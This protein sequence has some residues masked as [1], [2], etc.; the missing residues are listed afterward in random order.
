M[1]PAAEPTWDDIVEQLRELRATRGNP[2]FATL[3]D[4]VDRLRTAR[5]DRFHRPGRS[6]VFDAFQPGR[7]RVDTDLV[8][9][10]VAALGGTPD[11]I[12][13]W[14][15]LCGRANRARAVPVLARTDLPPPVP[16]FAGRQD[17]VRSVLDEATGPARP[18]AWALTGLGGVG[19]S[20]LALA[21]AAE[22]V[23]EGHA[24][25]TA[26]VDLRGFDPT[27]GPATPAA[28]LEAL[29]PVLG[30]A[31]PRTLA[32]RREAFVEAMREHR[33]VLVVENARDLQDLALL[34][35]EDSRSTV[36]I[37]SRDRLG[38]LRTGGTVRHLE[39]RP[40]AA[41]HA[42]D[43]L[44]SL[45]GHDA[46]AVSADMAGALVEAV[47]R[48]P[49]AVSLLA[50]RMRAQ[51]DWT[52]Q[53]HLAQLVDRR[54]LLRL[55][56]PVMESVRTSY[57]GLDGAAQ[58][59]LRLL[60]TQPCSSLD[61]A[62]VAALSGTELSLTEDL[63]ESLLAHHLV[64]LAPARL[65][66]RVSL[67][68]VVRLFGVHSGHEIDRP[69]EHA[70]ARRR[71]VEHQLAVLWGSRRHLRGV[72]ASSPPPVSCPDVVLDRSSTTAWLDDNLDTVVTLAL[73]TQDDAV[74]GRVSELVHDALMTRGR[75]T[76]MLGL[77]ERE[78]AAATRQGDD[79]GVAK[80]RLRQ[81]NA[82]VWQGRPEDAASLLRAARPGLRHLP[83]HEAAVLNSLALA[84]YYAGDL[85]ASY[86]VFEELRV[87]EST[88]DE[89]RLSA[90]WNAGLLLNDLGEHSAADEVL[91]L[92]FSR[93]DDPDD[94]VGCTWG[95]A[96]LAEALTVRGEH[97]AAVE[98]AERALALGAPEEAMLP[99]MHA[100]QVLATA[101]VGLG[102]CDAALDHLDELLPAARRGGNRQMER[103]VRD[104]LARAHLGRGD[105]A[106]ALHHAD[107]AMRLAEDLGHPLGVAEALVVLGDAAVATGDHT[108]AR[109]R[110]ARAAEILSA[111]GAA[112][113]RQVE[114]RL[115]GSPRAAG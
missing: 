19:K 92:A 4:R 8:L 9:D 48:M 103:A 50:G 86:A 91:Q 74:P 70:A 16:G 98:H 34:V 80:A 12:S 49:L 99:R 45:L 20:Q 75:F 54:S 77:A 85:R 53:D 112:A 44:L 24:E 106:E 42:G 37:T 3:V 61:V 96:N 25:R 60:A 32:A 23:R 52:P 108:T 17:E 41:R 5:G 64:D 110:W 71:L 28:A 79:V 102:R 21:I 104:L 82:L 39:V 56:E 51:R 113:A 66:P 36:L 81:G 95:H 15:R 89:I 97:E 1:P 11:E 94:P 68:D 78:L 111:C 83:D 88:P 26:L 30:A 63:V 18:D 35:P 57:E 107:R 46:E 59:L 114:D 2:S 62:A 69:S 73:T 6:T 27:V 72:L 93:A 40:V 65:R 13:Q 67:H 109:E 55:D 7:R 101:L 115:R 31:V 29:L 84:S 105:L 43:L 33:W 87:Q 22:L 14:A 100:T 58:R 10:L 38:G 76:D 90:E 47:G